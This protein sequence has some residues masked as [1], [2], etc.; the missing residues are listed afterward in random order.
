MALAC[1]GT[2]VGISAFLTVFIGWKMTDGTERIRM[3][4][5]KKKISVT[6]IFKEYLSLIKL[7]TVRYLML[8]SIL[9]LIAYTMMTTGKVFIHI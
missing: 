3:N 7:K 8:G 4:L 9:S 2:I 1:V 6:N 5:P